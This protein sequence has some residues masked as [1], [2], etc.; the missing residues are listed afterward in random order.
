MAVI[1]A[2]IP[3]KTTRDLFSGKAISA[4]FTGKGWREHLNILDTP[5]LS[6][7]QA[8]E[9]LAKLALEYDFSFFEYWI[10]DH[11]GHKSNLDQSIKVVEDLDTML[12]GLTSNWDLCQDIIFI[13]SDHGNLED[14]NTRKHTLNKVPALIIGAQHIRDSLRQSLYNLTDITPAILELFV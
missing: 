5:L 6:L 4:D 2:G 9:Q 7:R 11:A 1:S 14:S 12:G 8:G 10:S 3:L 13:T